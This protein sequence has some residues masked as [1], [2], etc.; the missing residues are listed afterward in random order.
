MVAENQIEDYVIFHGP[1]YGEQ[2][3]AVFDRSDLGIGS[4]A[5]H[6]SGITHIK[7]LKN[8]EYAARGIPFLYSETDEDFEQAPYILKIPP[9]EDPL[10]I[11]A[12]LRFYRNVRMTP[13]EIRQSIENT[14]TW[15]VQMQQVVNEL[16]N[17][18]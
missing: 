13:E 12:V 16:W 1:L 10:D 15:K 17:E 2:L 14:L 5:R 4:L 18:N 11:E 7:T 8:R 6:R 9:T 3:D